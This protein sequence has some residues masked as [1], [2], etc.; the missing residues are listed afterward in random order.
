MGECDTAAVGG[1]RSLRMTTLQ[2]DRAGGFRFLPRF[3]RETADA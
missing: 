1:G 3:E 2:H